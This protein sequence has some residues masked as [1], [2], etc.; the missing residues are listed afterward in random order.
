MQYRVVRSENQLNFERE[1]TKLLNEGWQLFGDLVWHD[2]EFI[3]EVILEDDDEE[4]EDEDFDFGEDEEDNL[5]MKK[6]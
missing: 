3:R 5:G 4:D 1:I 2:G 6:N